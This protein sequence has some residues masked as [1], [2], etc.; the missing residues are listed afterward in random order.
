MKSS[1]LE[2]LAIFVPKEHIAEF[3]KIVTSGL[4]H[5]DIPDNIRRSLRD[6]WSVESDMLNLAASTQTN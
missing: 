4:Q 3:D 5:A 2:D 1:N 6:W